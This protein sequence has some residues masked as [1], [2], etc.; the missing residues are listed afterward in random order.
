MERVAHNMDRRY[1]MQGLLTHTREGCQVRVH[2]LDST[3]RWNFFAE[4]CL[5]AQY[6]RAS[7]HQIGRICRE[8]SGLRASACAERIN[9]HGEMSS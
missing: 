1:P 4:L 3:Q 7:L 2:I 8:R 6:S 9:A 5:L